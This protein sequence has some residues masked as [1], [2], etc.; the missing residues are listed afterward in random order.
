MTKF[1][2]YYTLK[3]LKANQDQNFCDCQC[4]AAIESV[5]LVPGPPGVW[6]QML[7]KH[8]RRVKQTQQKLIAA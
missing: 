8:N 3:L 5:P 2:A 7:L 6:L 1:R 4:H